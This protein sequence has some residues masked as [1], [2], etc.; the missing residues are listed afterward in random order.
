MARTDP[1]RVLQKVGALLVEDADGLHFPDEALPKLQAVVEVAARVTDARGLDALHDLVKLSLALA[2]GGHAR[3]ADAVKA[4]LRGSPAALR[5]LATA[6]ERDKDIHAALER[7]TDA[8]AVKRAPRIDQAVD[9]G[10]ALK[11]LL[12]PGVGQRLDATERA[13]RKSAGAPDRFTR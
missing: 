1:S 12:R 6:R 2:D 10:V 4:A 13:A 9:A 8:R 3:G 5:R 11:D 7:F